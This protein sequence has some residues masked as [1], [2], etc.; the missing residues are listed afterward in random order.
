MPATRNT[1]CTP[2][3]TAALAASLLA[4]AAAQDAPALPAGEY[5]VR[6]VNGDTT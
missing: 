6:F 4:G 3:V 1:I 5:V 2:L